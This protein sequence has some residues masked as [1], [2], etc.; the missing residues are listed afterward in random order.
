MK[1]QKEIGW[2]KFLKIR[3]LWRRE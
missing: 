3:R 2:R 1:S